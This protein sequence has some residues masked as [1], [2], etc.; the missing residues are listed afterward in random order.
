MD[1]VFHNQGKVT[2]NKLYVKKKGSASFSDSPCPCVPYGFSLPLGVKMAI[3]SFSRTTP[4]DGFSGLGRHI[5]GVIR[6]AGR[7]L[8]GLDGGILFGMNTPPLVLIKYQIMCKCLSIEAGVMYKLDLVKLLPY[9]PL[10]ATILG[11]PRA[12]LCLLWLISGMKN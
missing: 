9:R 10:W 2:E 3:G 4:A 8:W 12:F 11:C 6:T 7:L 5:M 1:A